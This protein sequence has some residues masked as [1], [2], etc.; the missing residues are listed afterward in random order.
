MEPIKLTHDNMDQ[1]H[2]CCT[3][4]GNRDVQVMSQKA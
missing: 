2:L 4:S 3:I 1:E